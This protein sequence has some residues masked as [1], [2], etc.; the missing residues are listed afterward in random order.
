MKVSAVDSCLGRGDAD[1]PVAPVQQLGKIRSVQQLHRTGSKTLVRQGGPLRRQPTHRRRKDVRWRI[2]SRW[3]TA[4]RRGRAPP[5]ARARCAARARCPANPGP[6]DRAAAPA[7]TSVRKPSAESDARPAP[8]CPDAAPATAARD[9]RSTARRK[10]RSSRKPWSADQ[11]LE[12]S[13]G[14]EHEP[15]VDRPV[16]VLSD[17]LDGRAPRARAAA[18]GCMSSGSSPTSSR[19]TVPPSAAS[20][21]PG[22]RPMRAGESAPS[23]AEQL[24]FHSLWRQRAAVDCHERPARAGRCDRG[25]RAPPAPCRCRS[26]PR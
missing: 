15:H 5:G 16:V 2:G 24:G 17:A 12:V 22:T 26:R 6:S 20:M 4:S 23:M 9:S 1:P 21:A 25:A 18:C 8:G 11:L 14:G 3:D 13:V 19:N 7:V 10:K